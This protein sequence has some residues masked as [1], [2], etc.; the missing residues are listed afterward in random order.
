METEYMADGPFIAK[1]EC[2]G[3]YYIY[4]VNSNH[5]L[6][7]DKAVYSAIDYWKLCSLRGAQEKLRE[8]HA[9][10]EIRKAWRQI[11]GF[12]K[13]GF[14]SSSRPR[15]VAYAKPFAQIRK[16]L[17]SSLA[18]IV[19]NI[20]EDCNLRCAYCV[21]SG[22]YKYRREHSL[23]EMPR[24][25]AFKAVDF[26]LQHSKASEEAT[27]GFYGGEPFLN[28]KL[29]EDIVA[30]VEGKDGDNRIRFNLT[31]NGTILT[32]RILDFIVAH[33]V[34]MLVSLDGPQEVHDRH[35]VFKSGKGS[36]ETVMKNLERICR[37]NPEYFERQVSFSTVLG[38]PREM[39]K[40]HDFIS[41]TELL[42]KARFSA[43]DIDNRETD[44]FKQFSKEDLKSSDYPAMEKLFTER[45]TGGGEAG[46]S[47]LQ[48]LVG[49]GLLKI[50]KRDI[51]HKMRRYEHPNGVCVPGLRRIFVSTEGNFYICE[52]VNEGLS[53]GNAED[54]LDLRKIESIMEDYAKRSSP[55]CRECWAIRLCS[56]CFIHVVTDKLD[57]ENKEDCCRVHKE[58]LL[59]NLKLYCGILQA[60]PNA[61]EYMRNIVLS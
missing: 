41:E 17:N 50:Y 30:Y 46:S 2:G 29:I 9:G 18:Q 48:S 47:F 59:H 22:K 10:N 53:I 49:Q 35:R 54:G 40:I 51:G 45:V 13:R 1:F 42:K 5:I 19:L 33:N 37:H 28:F 7:V 15:G 25:V 57:F 20:T 12:A 60:N 8:N 16:Q 31:T 55:R 43:G 61:L 34:R 39:A 3:N 36:F 6:N 38:P 27:I 23:R 4:D 58:A 21:Y 14:F 26:F 52:K 56:L 44:V 24:S 32:D 11:G